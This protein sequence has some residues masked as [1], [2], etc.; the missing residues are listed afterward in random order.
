M[1]NLWNIKYDQTDINC[2]TQAINNKTVTQ[3]VLTQELEQKLAKKLKVPYVVCCS[4]GT[5]ALTMSFMAIGVKP[6]DE[7]I[8]P[9]RTYIAT[10]NAGMI[11]GVKIVCVD[12]DKETQLMNI[13]QIETLITSK[14][15]AIV[16]V[17]LNGKMVNMEAIQNIARKHQID[18]VEDAAQS[19][20]SKQNDS[21]AGT[22]SRFGCFS[23]GITKVFSTV[24]GGF[25][26]CHNDKDYEKLLRIRNQGVFDV[27]KEFEPLCLSY[28]FKYSDIYA[29]IGL[30]QIEKI[31]KL[32]QRQREIYQLYEQ[33]LANIP[34]LKIL[35]M[36]TEIETPMRPI[37]LSPKRE[38]I[39]RILNENGVMC[40]RDMGS[41][42]KAKHINISRSFKNADIFDQEALI[43]PAGP[44]QELTDIEQVIE[45]I[46]NLN[47]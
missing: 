39:I 36:N 38:K 14:T 34:Y 5:A 35:E 12:V 21:Y 43:F 16:P 17:H 26:V 9:A 6:Y 22:L 8:I 24:S 27:R 4:S 10:A 32:V 40:C 42:D 3:G 41:I 2:L 13:D 28:N 11:L 47:F 29:S 19:I 1:I 7:I 33:G 23:L 31:E 30:N 46:K 45:I 15:K 20:L 37:F 18:I 25:V 44:S